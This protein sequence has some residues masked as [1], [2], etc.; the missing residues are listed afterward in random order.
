MS[1]ELFPMGHGMAIICGRKPKKR[2]RCKYHKEN[3][4]ATKLCD[5]QQYGGPSCDLPVC[6]DCATLVG[7]DRHHCPAHRNLTSHSRELQTGDV[8]LV[9]RGLRDGHTLLVGEP[10]PV[11]RGEK[12]W[13]IL[14]QTEGRKGTVTERELANAGAIWA[15]QMGQ[16]ETMDHHPN[17][18]RN[19]S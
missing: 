8:L 13:W 17:P 1:C 18:E 2:L 12:R 15:D 14:D 7:Q 16:T 10:A 5:Y 11:V 3:V 9:R 4:A 6:D 19:E